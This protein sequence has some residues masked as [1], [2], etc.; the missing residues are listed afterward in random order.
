MRDLI[1][2]NNVV[3]LFPGRIERLT[4][5]RRRALEDEKAECREKMTPFLMRAMQI[6]KIL[7]HQETDDLSAA[8][9]L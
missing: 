5:A 2:G 7:R 6:S 3:D 1:G 9:D 4:P 8:R